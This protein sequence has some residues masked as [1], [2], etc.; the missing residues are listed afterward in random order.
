MFQSLM[1]VVGSSCNLSTSIGHTEE[2][3]INGRVQD[4][5]R[6]HL[7]PSRNWGNAFKMGGV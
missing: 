2:L 7:F 6:K 4:V 3:G 5:R 1:G